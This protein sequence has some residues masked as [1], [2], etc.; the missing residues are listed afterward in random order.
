[1]GCLS[2]VGAKDGEWDVC[3]KYAQDIEKLL[4]SAKI[5]RVIFIQMTLQTSIYRVS[6]RIE[7]FLF[8]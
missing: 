8:K 7:R 3:P 6:L 4:E 5:Y 2:K 1:V